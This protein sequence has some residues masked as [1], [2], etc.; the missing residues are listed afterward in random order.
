LVFKNNER[1]MMNN[2]QTW[3]ETPNTVRIAIVQVQVLVGGVLTTKYLST[4]AVTVDGIEYL[5]V[6]KGTITLEESISTNYSAAISF[7]DIEIANSSGQYDSWLDNVWVNKPIKIYIGSLPATGVSNTL[8]DFELIFDGVVADIDSKSRS[9]LN[10]KIR[11]KLQKLNTSVSEDLLGNY[12]Q[13]TIVSETTTVNQFRNN[14]KPLV[15]GEVHNITPLLTD[16]TL[17][18][19]MVNAEAVEQIIEVRDNGVPVPFEISGTVVIPPGS[20]RLLRAPVGAI[21]CSV[22]GVKR[23]VNIQN[24]TAVDIY[25][26]TVS[27]TIAT[28]LKFYGEQLEYTEL[29]NTSFQNLGTEAVGVYIS[30]R[31]NVLSICQEI[32]KSSGLIVSTTRTGKVKLVDLKIP[33]SANI[34]IQDSDMLLNSLQLVEKLPVIAAVKLGYAKNWT[35]QNNLLTGIPEQHKVLYSTEWL[36]STSKDAASKIAYE[37]TVEPT[38]ESTY[39]ID[40]TQA[41]AVALKK[42]QLFKTQR[43]IY[44]M[45]CTAKFLNVQVGDAVTLTT[46]RFGLNSGSVGLVVSAKPNWLRGNIEI[47]VLI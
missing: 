37:I 4:H 24:S 6:I 16:P 22:Q 32:A 40:K 36:E 10:I 30:D 1:S 29:D 15:F 44:R 34:N 38:L 35:V 33:V 2:Y 27:N 31:Q 17:L 13:G 8:L 28:L 21:T 23:T 43:R 14:L 47:G 7:G 5:P 11:D 25:T 26:N 19:Y 46:T 9:E 41:D 20:F 39:L 18:E 3:L 12:F 45:V 42:L